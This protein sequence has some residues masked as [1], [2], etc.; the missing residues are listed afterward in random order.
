MNSRI[1][2][3]QKEIK[4][5]DLK[6]NAIKILINSFYGAFGNRYFYFH[7]N[8]IAQSI[9]LQGQDLIK[10]AIKAINHYFTNMWHKDYEL[11]E[12][13]GLSK[14]TI[15]KI[16]N[17]AAIY[18]DTDSVYSCIEYAINSIEGLELTEQEALDFVIKINEY[19]LKE[20]FVKV[21]E[22]YAKHFHTGNRQNFELESISRAGI[23]VAKKKYVLEVVSKGDRLRKPDL[24]IKGLEA[25]QSSYPIWARDN[26]KQIY[27]LLLKKG[28]D[29]DLENDLIPVMQE[30]RDEMENLDIDTIAFNFNVRVF[31][32]YLTSLVPLKIEKGMP[33][34]G[35]ASAYHNHIIKKTQNQKYPLLRSGAKIKFYYTNPEENEYDF[36]VFAYSPGE[37]PDFAI[38]IDRDHQF[39]RLIVEPINKLLTAMGFWTINEKLTRQVKVVKTR[40]RAKNISDED[41][42]PLY[43][44]NSETLEWKEM[45]EE[46]QEYIGKD[47]PVPDE[48]FPTYLASITTF[49]LSTVIVPKFELDKYLARMGK[50][51]GIEVEDPFAVPYSEM[52]AL[53]RDNGWET[54]PENDD[55]WLKINAKIKT[56]EK[57]IP[58][59]NAYGRAT[60]AIERA[61]Q[62]EQEQKKKGK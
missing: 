29:L 23:Y 44:V 15:N 6:Q 7:N 3:L 48:I 60:R 32:K 9:T 28:Y 34:Y 58:T 54:H 41:I 40:S 31:E 12:K 16:E 13:L 25:I 43:A 10:F 4:T 24:L 55:M 62:K 49:G 61:K 50:K 2:S 53:L 38:P 20:Y 45:P 46:C 1:E 21:F 35:R 22:K 18:T 39:F 33:I 56:L 19:R 5:L 42:Y 57:A 26:L 11:H 17:D 47:I 30:M 37:L 27:W 36:D 59:K 14:Y 52:A 51:L 8:D